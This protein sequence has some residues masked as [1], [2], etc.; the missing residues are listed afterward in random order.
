MSPY[1]T[2]PR[3][4]DLA[5]RRRLSYMLGIADHGNETT[6]LKPGFSKSY[7]G[8]CS[9]NSPYEVSRDAVTLNEPLVV[10]SKTRKLL[11]RDYPLDSITTVAI[12]VVTY[13]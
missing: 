10:S 5:S 11:V 3:S 7:T 12:T 4:R 1:S 13:S 9:V 2:L 6:L 8:H